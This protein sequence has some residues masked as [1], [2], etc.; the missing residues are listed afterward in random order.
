M[1]EILEHPSTTRG[2]SNDEMILKFDVNLTVQ[3]FT[4]SW[5]ENDLEEPATYT[6]SPWWNSQR[7]TWV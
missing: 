7:A 1:S 6:L 2:L 5:C 4:K 3:L